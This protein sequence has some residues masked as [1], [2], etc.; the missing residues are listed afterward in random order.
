[1]GEVYLAADTKL[2]RQVALKV[3]LSEVAGDE[4]RVRR[5]V[6]EAKA[7]SALNHPNILTVYEIGETD[8]GTNYIAT[9]LIDGK[10]LREHIAHGTPLPLNTILKI[11]AQVAE[12]LSAAHH[13][14]IIHRDIK[15][16]NIMVRRDG[17]LKVLDFG[18]AKLSETPPETSL[19]EDPTRLQVKTTPGMIMGTVSY[20]SPEQMRGKDTDARTDLWSLGVVLYEMF[21]RVSPFEGETKSDTCANV[22]TKAPPP[23]AQFVPGAPAELQRIVLKA[24]AKERDER[25]QTARDLMNDLKRLRRSPEMSGEIERLP[26]TS[27]ASGLS[28]TAK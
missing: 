25:Y 10:S 16:E 19:T 1:M 12:A 3:L 23:L 15:P 9:E 2:D 17:Y 5:F 8:D 11:G 22:L 24:L 27:G 18:L 21:T 7:A 4:D 6:R 28:T 20:M 26:H 13:A 14:G